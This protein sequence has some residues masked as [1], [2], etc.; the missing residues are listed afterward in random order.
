MRLSCSLCA[1]VRSS[2]LPSSRQV[3]VRPRLRPQLKWEAQKTTTTTRRP[4]LAGCCAH[5]SRLRAWRDPTWWSSPGVFQHLNRPQRPAEV[6][7][8]TSCVHAAVVMCSPACMCVC[9][10]SLV[11]PRRRRASVSRAPRAHAHSATGTAA[12]RPGSPAFATPPPSR[13]PRLPPPSRRPLAALVPPSRRPRAALAALVAHVP[14][15]SV[16][17]AS[18]AANSFGCRR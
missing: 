10:R 3:L 18:L 8:H 14:P 2:C 1:L 7:K 5:S 6:G 9:A 13:H 4:P 11:S 15:S 17:A 12:L 16:T